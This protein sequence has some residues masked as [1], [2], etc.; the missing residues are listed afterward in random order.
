MTTE[1]VTAIAREIAARLTALENECIDLVDDAS[2]ARLHH[3]RLRLERM[4]N[5]AKTTAHGLRIQATRIAA[6]ETLDT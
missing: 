2:A 3:A 5:I 1:E 4:R 6:R